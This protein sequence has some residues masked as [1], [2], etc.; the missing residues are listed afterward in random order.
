MIIHA[1]SDWQHDRMGDS[2]VDI[3]SFF[4]RV[5]KEKR[6]WSMVDLQGYPMPAT[7]LRQYP[8]ISAS[9]RKTVKYTILVTEL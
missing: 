9:K 2:P 7:Y 3:P 4:I 8:R 1:G 5:G 6:Q